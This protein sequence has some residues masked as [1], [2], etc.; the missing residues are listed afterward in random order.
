MTA[1]LTE[2][3][4]DKVLSRRAIR[5]WIDRAR[6]RGAMASP[7]RIEPR[8]AGGHKNWTNYWHLC[9]L[10]LQYLTRAI[11]HLILFRPINEREIELVSNE[12]LPVPKNEIQIR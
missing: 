6:R 8:G 11:T 7:R 4:Q 2:L 5:E 12:Y 3:T 1:I 9:L 10:I